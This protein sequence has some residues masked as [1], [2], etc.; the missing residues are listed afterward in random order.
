MP[1]ATETFIHYTATFS[2]VCFK[3]VCVCVC[4]CVCV[5]VWLQGEKKHNY[6]HNIEMDMNDDQ[7][8]KVLWL[9]ACAHHELG[10]LEGAS[11]SIRLL[12]KRVPTSVRV[13]NKYVEHNLVTL[14]PYPSS[15]LT[16]SP[17]PLFCEC[18][19]CKTRH[20]SQTLINSEGLLS[21]AHTLPSMPGTTTFTSTMA[22]L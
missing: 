18:F 20:F 5:F 11:E 10:N 13:W 14:V 2:R 8:N 6:M 21:C 12:M 19:V 15:C 7:K 9:L 4:V 16:L 3:I 1:R 22:T 17:H